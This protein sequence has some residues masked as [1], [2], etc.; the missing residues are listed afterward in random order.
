VKQL[1]TIILTL[2]A[3]ALAMSA[4]PALAHEGHDDG[5]AT[6]GAAAAQGRPI[7]VSVLTGGAEV[8]AT[9]APDQGDLDGGAVARVQL[10]PFRERV[11][12]ETEAQ[13]I[14]PLTLAHIHRGAAGTNG[15]V[16]VDFAPLIDGV[17]VDGCVR[18]P[19]DTINAIAA[20]PAGYYINL[21]N[22]EFPRGAIRGQLEPRGNLRGDFRFPLSG[23]SEVGTPGDPDGSGTA[24][25]TFTA[26]SF[27]VCISARTSKV[28]DL[29]LAHIHQGAAGVNGPVVVDFTHLID[30]SRVRGCVTANPNVLDAIRTNPAGFYVNLH[31]AEFP[32]GAVRGQ[33]Q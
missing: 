24:R 8:D 12:I 4:M 26:R 14:A 33:L 13:N 17:T 11:C 3:C 18:A 10:I 19:R 15:P 6:T 2:I 29:T 9:G 25:I 32:R 30:G 1:R 21:H 5:G 7:F 20:D 16:V 23:A 31:T 22:A 28:G 27:E